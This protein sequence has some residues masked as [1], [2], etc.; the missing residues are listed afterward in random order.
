VEYKLWENKNAEIK[1]LNSMQ[2][3][4]LGRKSGQARRQ[5]QRKGDEHSRASS[6]IENEEGRNANFESYGRE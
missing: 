1:T 5:A 3:G 4:G 2:W 6:L